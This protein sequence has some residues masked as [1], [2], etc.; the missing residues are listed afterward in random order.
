V[1][2]HVQ[3]TPALMAALLCAV[4]WFGL[5][6]IPFR[7]L[8]DRPVK[9]AAVPDVV[10]LAADDDAVRV[11]RDPT[12]FALPSENGF[13]GDFPSGRI[14]LS[15]RLE[16]ESDP[17]RFLPRPAP[18]PAVL[19]SDELLGDDPR[20]QQALPERMKRPYPD[21]LPQ[22]PGRLFLSP[23]LQARA[24]G[25]L[26]IAAGITNLPETVRAHLS[27]RADGTVERVM[28][29]TPVENP[30]L[31][32]ALRRLRFTPDDRPAAGEISIRFLPEEES[33]S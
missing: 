26:R 33:A 28:L 15:L 3:W 10:Y 13:S 23:E 6:L 30:A 17:V 8:R 22:D 1:K 11:L 32:P 29:H 5:W 20:R 21:S 25:T 27:I 18:R 19:N 4:V 7:P 9:D 16:K 12:L 31:L 14:R 24:A 2:R